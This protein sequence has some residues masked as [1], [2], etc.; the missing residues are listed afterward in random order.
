MAWELHFLN[1]IE[2]TLNR[3]LRHPTA[4]HTLA[5][6]HHVLNR[7]PL[8]VCF[9]VRV[10]LF[11]KSFF[12]TIGR[13]PLRS[14]LNLSK[15]VVPTHRTLLLAPVHLHFPKA[16]TLALNRLRSIGK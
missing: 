14:V 10:A 11:H 16:A 13:S 2:A 5:P 4:W 3:I 9:S 8:L 1:E 7:G 15:A 6:H 12:V